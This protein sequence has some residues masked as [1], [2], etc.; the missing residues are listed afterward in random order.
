M[1]TQR[2]DGSETRFTWSKSLFRKEAKHR[3]WDNIILSFRGSVLNFAI[4]STFRS[5]GSK[6]FH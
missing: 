4:E 2:Q 1:A 5:D 3:S 6:I